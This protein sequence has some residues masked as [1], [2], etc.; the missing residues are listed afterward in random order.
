[1]NLEE[2]E[3]AK[4]NETSIPMVVVLMWMCKRDGG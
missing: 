2:E 1:M 3:E 4:S